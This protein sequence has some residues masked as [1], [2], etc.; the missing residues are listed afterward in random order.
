MTPVTLQKYV[1]KLGQYEVT[2]II[3]TAANTASPAQDKIQYR[4]G[5]KCPS[6]APAP[7]TNLTFTTAVTSGVTARNAAVVVRLEN[8]GGANNWQLYCVDV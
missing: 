4:L 3:A 2:D 7:G 5:A 1:D 6:A 8:G